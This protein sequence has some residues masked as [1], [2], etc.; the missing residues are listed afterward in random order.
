MFEESF[1]LPFLQRNQ[2]IQIM[3]I[4]NTVDF[5]MLVVLTVSITVKCISNVIYITFEIKVSSRRT[6]VISVRTANI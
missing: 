4:N 2:F 5:N 6:T 1:P 3:L